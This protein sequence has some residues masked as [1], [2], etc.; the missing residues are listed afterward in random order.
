MISFD[1]PLKRHDI[2]EADRITILLERKEEQLRG[3]ETK[4]LHVH[5]VTKKHADHNQIQVE[6]LMLVLSKEDAPLNELPDM[7]TN[8]RY[9][10]EHGAEPQFVYNFVHILHGERTPGKCFLL[11]IIICALVKKWRYEKKKGAKTESDKAYEPSYVAQTIRTLFYWFLDND[12]WYKCAEFTG[13]ELQHCVYCLFSVLIYSS[14][15]LLYY[16]FLLLFIEGEF[17]AVSKVN[18]KK[19]R[20]AC[21]TYDTSANHASMDMEAP[22]KVAYCSDIHPFTNLLH[23]QMVVAFGFGALFGMCI[24]EVANLTWERVLFD[25]EHIILALKGLCTITLADGF[26]K[27]HQQ[28]L[29][30][31]TARRQT[32]GKFC[33]IIEDSE[34][35]HCLVKV[36]YTYREPCSDQQKYVLTYPTKNKKARV[37]RKEGQKVWPFDSRDGQKVGVNTIREWVLQ[38]SRLCKFVVPKECI[39]SFYGLRHV[40]ISRMAINGVALAESMALAHHS[41]VQVH[42]VYQEARKATREKRLLSQRANKDV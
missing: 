20:K 29:M 23:M 28:S 27:S 37:W 4:E 33:D 35:P 38:L 34:A 10:R 18:F 13:R 17:H 12:I 26:D 6:A 39:E 1:E 24:E 2:M 32:E 25:T 3:V 30:K 21:P 22:E 16:C 14:L 5:F 11:N 8:D 15:T 40:C 19:V 9:I 36:I 42:D 7:V 31:P 41:S